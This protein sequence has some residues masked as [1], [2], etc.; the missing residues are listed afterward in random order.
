MAPAIWTI[1]HST[2]SIDELV[3]LLRAHDV[4]QVIDVRTIPRSRHN[5]QFNRDR[6]SGSLTHEGLAYRHLPQLGG[7]RKPIKESINTGWRN[8]SF[9]GYA[10]YMQTGEFEKGL[11][12]LMDC[13]GGAH[14]AIMCAEAVPW[15]CHRSLIADALVVRGWTVRHILS[16]TKAEDHHLTSFARVEGDKIVYPPTADQR[17]SLPLF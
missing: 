10:D 2:H 17:S 6:L 11:D 3:A 8:I 5:P 14:T 9:R 13:A 15:R 1:G 12:M 4:R 16:G 7:L